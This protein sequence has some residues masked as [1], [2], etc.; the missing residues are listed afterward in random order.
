[1]F[2]PN[3]EVVGVTADAVDA[4]FFAL[5]VFPPFDLRLGQEAMG[6]DILDAADKDKIRGALN[7]GAD[8][9][10]TASQSDLGI[11]PPASPQSPWGR[12]Q[13]ARDQIQ[14]VL[15]EQSGLFSNPGHGLGHGL[16]RMDGREFIR[17]RDR[18]RTKADRQSDGEKQLGSDMN[19]P[20]ADQNS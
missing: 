17:R 13:C 9:S 14:V 6:Q 4:D 3:G 7:V 1:L 8:D 19:F 5:E 20:E 11:S 2:E 10:L 16:R 18:G 15:L 12:R